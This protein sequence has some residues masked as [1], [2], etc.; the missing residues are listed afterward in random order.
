MSDSKTDTVNTI[1]ITV[2]GL[3]I[4]LIAGYF[5]GRGERPAIS[6]AALSGQT[7]TENCPHVLDAKDRWILDGFRCPGSADSQV[8]LNDC[9]C[10]VAHEIQDRVRAALTAGKSGEQI[11]EEIIAEYGD[12]L[13]FAGQ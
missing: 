1:L 8:P 2:V 6:D 5:I 4:G 13:K 3:L 11:R 10:V 12:R 7:S 9:H